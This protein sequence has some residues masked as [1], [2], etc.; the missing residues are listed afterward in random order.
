[1]TFV[2]MT[3]PEP[4]SSFCV[5][6]TDPS[7]APSSAFPTVLTQAEEEE[8]VM[9]KRSALMMAGGLALSLLVGVVAMSLMVGG[10]S[11]AN[12]GRQH[13]PIVKHQIE[14]VTVHRKANTPPTGGVR[15][16]HLSPSSASGSVVSAGSSDDSF[17]SEGTADG[18]DDGSFGSSGR[19]SGS[20]FGDD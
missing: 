13:E 16:I 15:V 7:P 17:E 2:R 14:T 5:G 11:V 8:D 18:S 1:M 6:L 3:G 9:T 12:A 4:P 10:T 20:S 19:S